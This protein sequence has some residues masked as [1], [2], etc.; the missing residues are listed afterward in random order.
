MPLTRLATGRQAEGRPD[1]FLREQLPAARTV[2]LPQTRHGL[3]GDGATGQGASAI[4][5]MYLWLT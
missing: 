4:S 3:E 1:L 2:R 5:S